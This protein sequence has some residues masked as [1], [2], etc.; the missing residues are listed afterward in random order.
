[1]A[2]TVLV[3]QKTSLVINVID[4]KLSSNSLLDRIVQQVRHPRPNSTAACLKKCFGR[5][6]VGRLL[7]GPPAGKV[8]YISQ[9]ANTEEVHRALDQ[10]LKMGERTNKIGNLWQYMSV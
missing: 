2:N 9:A 1:M 10:R 3:N 6:M 5:W 8:C 4:V 7:R